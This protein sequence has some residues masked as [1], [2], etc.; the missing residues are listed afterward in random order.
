MVTPI[1]FCRMAIS[2]KRVDSIAFVIAPLSYGG[3]SR[4]G[5]RSSCS[6]P[7]GSPK[8]G[9]DRLAHAFMDSW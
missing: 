9:F 8:V 1:Y 5:V 4:L 6:W 3:S 7:A 2:E